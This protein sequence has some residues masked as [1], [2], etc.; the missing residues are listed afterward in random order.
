MALLR[1]LEVRLGEPTEC[2]G[3]AALLLVLGGIVTASDI[4]EHFSRLAARV[5]ERETWVRAE[6]ETTKATVDAVA[7][8]ERALAAVRDAHA[9]AAQ[10]LVPVIALALFERRHGQRGNTSVVQALG[11]GAGGR[12]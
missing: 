7:N 4:A 11:H 8:D 2:L 6:G 10:R 9:E 12:L 1:D 3:V 5:G